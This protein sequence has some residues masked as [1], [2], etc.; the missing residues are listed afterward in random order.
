M[1]FHEHSELSTSRTY[2]PLRPETY[3]WAV[4]VWHK[5]CVIG[6]AFVQCR[7]PL[8]SWRVLCG[9]D[10]SFV[11]FCRL[12]M[13]VQFGSCNLCGA[14]GQLHF[15]GIFGRFVAWSVPISWQQTCDVFQENC[16][17]SLNSLIPEKSN[18]LLLWPASSLVTSA[19]S[20]W[21]ST[22]SLQCF[23]SYS[24]HGCT[25]EL[26]EPWTSFKVAYLWRTTRPAQVGCL[27]WVALPLISPCYC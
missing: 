4:G 18:L 2:Q 17:N 21:M 9:V 15:P 22:H 10:F 20:P 26:I 8:L 16:V 27:F 14:D 5:L 3:I 24:S 1:N 13:F 25:I 7:C 11:V 19:G 23:A 12:F 6:N